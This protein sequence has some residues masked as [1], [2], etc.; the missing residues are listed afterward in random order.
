MAPSTSV[1]RTVST[2]KGDNEGSSSGSSEETHEGPAH[3]G[4]SSGSNSSENA[5][6]VRGMACSLGSYGSTHVCSPR[7]TVE[8]GG[9][10]VGTEFTSPTLEPKLTQ[11]QEA[12]P[13][14]ITA[15]VTLHGGSSFGVE[16]TQTVDI[17]RETPARSM[18]TFPEPASTVVNTTGGYYS[19]HVETFEVSSDPGGSSSMGFMSR[20]SYRTPLPVP[21]CNVDEYEEGCWE[22]P[23][24][25]QV[26]EL[27]YL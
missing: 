1:R 26:S 16:Q 7:G 19:V 15:S 11:L 5:Q 21:R 13:A 4:R 2:D 22:L 3:G 9:L 6:G 10:A 24:E 12:D 25:T 8:S 23:E 20:Y 17:S 27:P 14:G 18:L